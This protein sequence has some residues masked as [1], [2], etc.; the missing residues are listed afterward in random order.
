MK[1]AIHQTQNSSVSKQDNEFDTKKW[2]NQ[3]QIT[4]KHHFTLNVN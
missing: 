3:S 2:T 4:K 1:E